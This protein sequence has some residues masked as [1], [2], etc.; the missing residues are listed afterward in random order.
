MRSVEGCE[1]I[2]A[3]VSDI[4]HPPI[5]RPER[6]GLARI[7]PQQGLNHPSFVEFSP[8]QSSQPSGG[9]TTGMRSCSGASSA[10]AVVV[11]MAKD[12]MLSPAGERH[13]SHNPTRSLLSK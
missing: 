10:F 4:A 1:Q 3:V 9:M 12:L 5:H 13:S 6:H 8:S 11:I 7:R 2:R